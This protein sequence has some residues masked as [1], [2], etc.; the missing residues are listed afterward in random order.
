[1][2]IIADRDISVRAT[3]DGMRPDVTP[4]QAVMSDDVCWCVAVDLMA[5]GTGSRA[6]PARGVQ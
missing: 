2:G 3:A 6:P 1:V 4:V 5:F